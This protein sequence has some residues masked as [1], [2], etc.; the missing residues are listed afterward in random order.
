MAP[1]PVLVAETTLPSGIGRPFGHVL[2]TY[3]D[4][5]CSAVVVTVD[6]PTGHALPIAEDTV[7][8]LGWTRPDTAAVLA[9]RPDGETLAYD[10]HLSADLVTWGSATVTGEVRRRIVAAGDGLVVFDREESSIRVASLADDGALTDLA[11]IEVPEGERW[12]AQHVAAYERSIGVVLIRPGADPF[13][14]VSTD[15][16]STW[17][18]PVALTSAG[19]DRETT[20]I[21]VHDG[22]FV[23]TGTHVV[24][25]GDVD[26]TVTYSHPIA[27]STADG[28]AVTEEA[29]PLPVFGL[30]GYVT[31]DGAPIETSTPWSDADYEVGTPILASDG[32][33]LFLGMGRADTYD[34]ARRR[35]DGSWA[36]DSPEVYLPQLVRTVAADGSGAILRADEKVWVHAAG[37]PQPV[38]SVELSAPRT[39]ETTGPDSRAHA[40]GTTRWKTSTVRRVG[41]DAGWINAATT[42]WF[43]VRPDRLEPA[44][45][46]PVERDQTFDVL[47]EAADDG[48]LGMFAE[49][50]SRLTS[51]GGI[52]EDAQGVGGWIR[53]E[54][55]T[56][57]PVSG[58]P[59]AGSFIG[60]SF[61]QIG[62]SYH[63]TGA[64]AANRRRVE[65]SPWTGA[66]WTSPDARSWTADGSFPPRSRVSDL[67]LLGEELVAVGHTW[68]EDDVDHAALFRRTG[69]QWTPT[70]VGGGSR[71]VAR[72]ARLVAG[73]LLVSGTED[74]LAVD[75]EIAADGSAREVYRATDESSRG[76]ILDLGEGALLATGWRRAP[77]GGGG[78][79]I[80]VSSDGGKHW[81]ITPIPG[82]AGRYDDASLMWDGE[83]VIVL[84]DTP[85]GP[86]AY[87]IVRA[88]ADVLSATSA[89]GASDGGG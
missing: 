29:V 55:G 41:V 52:A 33:E 74:G 86:H 73:A 56:W 31:R 59:T 8:L 13:L 9:E 4:Y 75:W 2:A 58:L 32:S 67:A 84:V 39:T 60:T 22:T 51:E 3:R 61:R 24:D 47:F 12:D 1:H 49:L 18:E 6:T 68:G 81:D 46:V 10:L 16:G 63:L 76:P 15:E 26:G 5:V 66:L 71:S 11:P 87:R 53:V 28:T 72:A 44:G 21:A 50:P 7:G 65:D 62:A 23:V 82:E 35:P 20:G 69:E 37:A 64:T 57:A 77:S 14:V 78:A 83:D 88:Q 25:P 70:P 80:W 19:R 38:D 40:G 45:D 36:T 34:L 48:T 17:G 27:W 54:D 30:D 89:R 42:R 79:V 85:D 43:T